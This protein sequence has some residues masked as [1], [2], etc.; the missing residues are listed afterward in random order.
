MIEF[1]CNLSCD[2]CM[3]MYVEQPWDGEDV[4]LLLR[5]AEGDGWKV[6][7]LA[8]DVYYGKAWCPYCRPD[9]CKRC[10][11]RGYYPK[12]PL[13]PYYGEPQKVDCEVCEGGGWTET[14]IGS[15]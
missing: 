6:Y 1:Y 14:P 13:D 9:K 12:W 5:T 8:R 4:A 11:G 7:R 15:D 2:V 3:K 10:N